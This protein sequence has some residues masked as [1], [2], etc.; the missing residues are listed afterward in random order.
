MLPSSTIP[1]RWKRASK[2]R[3]GVSLALFAVCLVPLFAC[4]ALAIDLG[5]LL[6]ARSQVSD[7]ADACALAGTRALN[8]NSGNNNNYSAVASTANSVV[9]ANSVLGSSLTASQL[10]LQI[11][12]YTYVSANQRFEGQF[13]GPSTENWNMV[14][15]T[16]TSDV[17]SKMGFSKIFNFTAPNMQAVATAVHRP[18]DICVIVDFSG[19]MRFSSL[20]SL[21][22]YGDRTSNNQ[23]PIRPSW[24]RYSSASAVMVGPPASSPYE[25]ANVTTTTSDGRPPIVQDFY[26]SASGGAAFTS[27]P[28]SYGATPAGDPSLKIN[29]N[30]GATFA[31]TLAQV[32][33]I[34][35]PANNTYD[36]NYESLGYAAYNMTSGMAGYTMGPGYYGKTFYLW[37]PDPSVS[38]GPAGVNDWR[39]R[40]F[41]Y[42]GTNTPMDDNSR[43]WDATGNFQSPSAATYSINYN[44]ILQFITSIGPNPFPARLQS[45]R[46]VYYTQIPNMIDT[47]VWP[48][49]DLNQR[50][51]K[52]Y[53]DYVIGTMQTGPGTYSDISNNTT[54]LTGYGNDFA[55]GTIKITPKSSLSGGNKTPFMHYGDN[56]QQP[57]LSFWFGPLTMIDFLGNYNL[58]YNVSPAC[59]R[60]CWWPGTC[61][62]S[63]MYE[64]KLGM[65]AALT[66]MN[67][68]HPSD[69]VSLIY[70]STPASAP[71]DTNGNRF[72]RV[73]VGL[74]HNYS[75]MLDSLWYPP[76]TI[77]NSSTVTPYDANN[78]EVPRAQGGTCYAYPL[79][80]AYNQFSCNTSLQTYNSSYPTGDAGGNGRK[81]AQKVIIFETDGAPNTTASASFANNGSYQS[82]YNIRY[83]S[84]NPG[85]SEYPSNVWGYANNDSTVTSQ[86]YSICTQLAGADT[87]SGY[88]TGN[89]PL[90]IH[91]LAFGPVGP[92]AA[93]TLNQ[94]QTIGNVKDG[95][96][97]Y[98]FINGNQSAVVNA[99]QTAISKI[100][101][102][103]VQVSL[104]Q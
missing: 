47:S 54:G 16:V 7:A 5:M 46:I 96:P 80:L 75:N 66:D 38:G 6:A 42:P 70:F 11:G 3:R 41:T 36:A 99:L 102:D 77:G 103:G 58:W 72:N 35:N 65:Q 100:L 84:A 21:P 40:Y 49:A 97:S 9:Q 34:N 31:Q 74:G 4:V 62:E 64:C 56:P 32:L 1:M 57:I 2:S 95:M 10:S 27:Q 39:K 85:G 50:F 86:I 81:G 76:S 43:M 18:R 68:N 73:R 44:A 59:S 55:W 94:M 28:S 25:N 71:N 104:I 23:D 26:T 30:A 78:L 87:G 33:N 82:F 51:W 13:P 19:S 91:C 37:P 8:G 24:G 17:N 101:Q 52:D 20:L 53:I 93:P 89:K 29:K 61:H 69:Q 12:R 83:N 88:S 45:G 48:P 92:E 98:K 15:A 22:Y 14:Q 63:P 90:L 79:M 67:N 60:Y